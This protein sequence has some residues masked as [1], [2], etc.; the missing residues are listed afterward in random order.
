MIFSLLYVILAAFGLGL[1]IFIHEF[2]HYWMARREGMTV[3]AFSIGFGKPIYTW[4]RDGVK[5]Q[6]C[7]LPFGGFV[8]IAGMEK[9][10]ALEPYEIHDGFYG[11]KPWS[12]IKV[13]L[14]GPIVNIVFAFI[15]F[16][17]LWAMGGR[18]K[19]FSDY[20][21]LVGSVDPYSGAYCAGIRPGDEITQINSKPFRN[22][23]D[24]IY[25]AILDD[26][27]PQINGLEID[28]LKQKSIPFQ[29][30]FDFDK[31]APIS[32]RIQ[33]LVS[34]LRPASYLIYNQ[35]ASLA[36]DTNSPMIDS[37]I[38]DGDRLL[39]V[40]GEVMFSQEQ[41]IQT[42]NEPKALLTVQRGSEFFLSRV[43]RL[44]IS[45]LRLNAVQKAEL[46]DWQHEAM[47]KGK[48]QDLF[49]IPYNL[50]NNCQVESLYSYLNA[51]SL[52]QQPAGSARSPMEV[53]LVCGDRI[54]AVDGLPVLSTY[55][56]L[57]LLQS[58]H[59]QIIV[60]KGNETSTVSWKD[61]DKAFVAGIRWDD[62]DKMVESI[63]T[64]APIAEMGNLKLLKP[65]A[66]KPL[67][68]LSISEEKREELQAHANAAMKEIQKIK[69]PEARQQAV[70]MF[71]QQQHK[72]K[73]GIAMSNRFVQYNPSPLVL[74][75]DVFQETWKTMVALFTGTIT[76]K[77]MTGP[78]GIVQV[79]QHSWGQGFKEAL[80]WLGMISM[81]LGILNLLPI[82]VLDG[83]HICFSIWEWITGR[84]IKS[85]TMERLI[86]PFVILLIALFV[87]LTYNDIMRLFTGIFT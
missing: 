64:K 50:T 2:G 87:Y 71:E 43:P 69:D 8:R 74:F 67:T 73:L 20:T 62:L 16:C 76:P 4:E 40:D 52:E 55:E 83:G 32:G 60:K 66:P 29:Y 81:N 18:S 5:W 21:H 11:K 3:E 70:Q 63:G 59:I 85:K 42:I 7:W 25:A 19:S 77:Y 28:Y 37:G 13:A 27:P 65:V 61:A 9:K 33:T 54:V 31:G 26:A 68:Q 47:L 12:R 41:L 58:R 44:K 84:P 6:F 57:N 45:D 75:V 22:F 86:I 30:Q 49:F 1:L 24:F 38:E 78:V 23:Q 46:E 82:P 17:V 79:M 53:P 56:M 72:L 51:D 48:V 35:N 15:A 14:A 39:W 34:T 36:F 80:F 10:G